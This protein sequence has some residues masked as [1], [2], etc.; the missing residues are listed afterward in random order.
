M[1]LVAG[2]TGS[3]GTKIVLGLLEQGNKVRVLARPT[4]NTASLRQAGAEIV[5]GDVKDPASL[6]R[7]CQ[8]ASAVIST[9]TASR[10]GDDAIE[11]VDGQGTRNLIEAAETAGVEHFVLVSTMGA[12]VD[13]PVPVFRAKG[14]AEA[15]LRNGRMRFTILQPNAF[16][17][18]W[19]AML[20]ES[21]IFS[22]R[23][24][25]LVGEARRRHSFVA[26]QDVAAYA[27]GCLGRDDARNTTLTIGGPDAISLRDVVGIYGSVLGRDIPV[28][29]VAPGEPIPGLP[30]PVWGIAAAL[31]GY[32]SPVPMD[33]LSRAYRTTP[34]SAGDLVRSRLAGSR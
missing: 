7:A 3:L 5:S 4:S 19:F 21:A 14:E 24:V 15:R 30:P 17:D 31:D 22:G 11:N 26:E 6:V 33:Q 23:P 25:T 29:S 12:S 2:G 20:I 8:G 1:I 18:V 32:D 28:Q 27:I 10:T 9:V 34:T 13:S 16:M